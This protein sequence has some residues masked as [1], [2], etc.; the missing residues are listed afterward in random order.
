[1]TSEYASPFTHPFSEMTSGTGLD[2]TFNWMN[3][4][5][6]QISFVNNESAVDGTSPSAISTASQSGISEVMLN[7]SNNPAAASDAS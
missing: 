4:F 2:E 6:H 7:G 3:G 5:D 1:M